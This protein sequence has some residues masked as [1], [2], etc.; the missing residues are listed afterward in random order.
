MDQSC[1][2]SQ[3]VLD[4]VRMAHVALAKREELR[5]RVPEPAERWRHLE[6]R[7]SSPRCAVITSENSSVRLSC[8]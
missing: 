5:L 7:P 6:P 2:L 4:V 3:V 1:L 8:A